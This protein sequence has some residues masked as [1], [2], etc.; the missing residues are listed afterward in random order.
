MV[1]KHRRLRPV[2]RAWL[3]FLGLSTGIIFLAGKIYSLEKS[4]ESMLVKEEAY[5]LKNLL[6]NV[7]ANSVSST[8]L[9]A[10][11]VEKDMIESDFDTLCNK[12]LNQNP[13]LDALQ[14]VEGE[15]IIRTFPLIGNEAVIGYNIFSDKDHRRAAEKAIARKKLYFEGPFEL[16]QGGMAMVGRLPIFKSGIFWGFSAVIIRM[17]SLRQALGIDTS[18]RSENYVYQLAKTDGNGAYTLFNFNEDPEFDKGIVA[19]VFIEEGDWMLFV[20]LLHPNYL[21]NSLLFLISGLLFSGM[22]AYFVYQKTIEPIRLKRQV[23]EKTRALA[24]ANQDLQKKAHDLYLSNQELE[25]FAYVA[26]H[27]LQ[28]PLR[29]ISSFVTLLGRKYGSVLDEKGLKYIDFAVDGAKRMRQIILDLLAYSRVGR[30]TDEVSPV[31]LSLI[32][33]EIEHLLRKQIR[34]KRAVIQYHDLPEFK[35]D[36]PLLLHLFQNLIENALKYNRSNETPIIHIN[37][38]SLEK[39]WLVAVRDNGIGI[40]EEYHDKIFLIFNR[41]HDNGTYEGTGIGLAIVKKTVEYFGGRI[42]LESEV[43]VGTTFYFTLPK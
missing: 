3:V 26:S 4:N 20:K 15:T 14:L 8:N 9:L 13:N 35:L 36:K 23:A 2:Q 5:N 31:Q 30:S 25:Q 34:E 22:V 28:E 11:L 17:E 16:Y 41:L 43:G 10:F 33:K 1:G 18:G 6:S 21:R 12:I 19:R 29:M 37:V 7:L 32:M 24:L 39:E 40:E 42:W 27:D 38:D